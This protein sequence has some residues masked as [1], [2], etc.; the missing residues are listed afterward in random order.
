MMI[1]AMDRFRKDLDIVGQRI[2][3]VEERVR[4]ARAA[5]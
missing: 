3:R 2:E 1:A 4:G 5:D